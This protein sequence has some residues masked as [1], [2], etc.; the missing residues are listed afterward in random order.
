MPAVNGS[1]TTHVLDTAT[2]RPAAG[3]AIGL[4]AFGEPNTYSLIV[5][6]GACDEALPRRSRLAMTARYDPGK[7]TS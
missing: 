1:L 7:L 2:G 6:R 5:A 3:I 4:H